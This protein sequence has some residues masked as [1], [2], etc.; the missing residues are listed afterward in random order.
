VRVF[1]YTHPSLL[2]LQ[3]GVGRAHDGH[4]YIITIIRINAV[5]GPKKESILPNEAKSL[6]AG[7]NKNAIEVTE[8]L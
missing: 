8:K 4:I 6:E 5:I 3:P 2:T 7:Q 1:L